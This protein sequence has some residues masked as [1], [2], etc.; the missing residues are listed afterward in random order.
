[1]RRSAAYLGLALSTVATLLFAIHVINVSAGDAVR[2]SGASDQP[3]SQRPALS[4]QTLSRLN[5][6][7]RSISPSLRL[8]G[9]S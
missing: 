2:F 7:R 6:L 1:M 8:Y 5:Q 3:S 9:L 4:H